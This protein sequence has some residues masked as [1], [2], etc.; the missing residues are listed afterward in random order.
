MSFYLSI[1]SLVSWSHGVDLSRFPPKMLRLEENPNGVVYT[2]PQNAAWSGKGFFNLTHVLPVAKQ[3]AG[4]CKIG[5]PN[6]F[7]YEA[8]RSIIVE[9]SGIEFPSHC[10]FK[11][12]NIKVAF[13]SRRGKMINIKHVTST[14]LLGDGAPFVSDGKCDGTSSAMLV[15]GHYFQAVQHY[16]IYL[17]VKV[18]Q[19]IFKETGVYE[20]EK[21]IKALLV[22]DDNRCNGVI[23]TEIRW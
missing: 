1:L 10:Q 2:L 19:I 3:T 15:P 17:Q 13:P 9:R 12:C 20:D 4:R 16:D 18:K 14:P 23:S 22:L 11:D 8:S 7:I 6:Q 21:V 5:S